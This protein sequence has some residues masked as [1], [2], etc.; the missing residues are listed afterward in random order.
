MVATNRRRVIQSAVALTALAVAGGNQR[1]RAGRGWCRS[2]PVIIIDN[3]LAD[4]FCTAPL[5]APLSITG[6]TEI[7]IS[8][9]VGVKTLLVL[10]GP[11]FGRGERVRF[12]ETNRLRQSRSAVEVEIAVYIPADERMDIGVEFA[13]RIVGILNPERAEGATNEWVTLK[14]TLTTGSLLLPQP[15]EP[16]A[17]QGGAER[18][19][20][21]PKR[22]RKRKAKHKR[23]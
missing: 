7:V 9:P 3:V 19:Q 10:A 21:K 1:A 5:T 2:D 12:A 23:R 17:T 20:P 11:G 4:V 18:G 13:P 16:S 14:T 6:P 15:A 8:V 22:K